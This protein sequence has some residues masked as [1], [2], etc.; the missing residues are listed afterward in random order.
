MAIVVQK[1][2]ELVEFLEKYDSISHMSFGSNNSKY[3][4]K[5]PSVLHDGHIK[6]INKAKKFGDV[7][8]AT[9][10]DSRA[11]WKY[12]FDKEYRNWYDNKEKSKF[13]SN[14]VVHEWA[15]FPYIDIVWI[16]D[17]N[18]AHNLF[19]P[20]ELDKKI[21]K[22]ENILE[23]ENISIKDTFEKN[24]IIFVMV[25]D[26]VRQWKKDYHTCCW[27]DG[28]YRFVQRYWAKKYMGYQVN[29]ID[30]VLDEYGIPFRETYL[31]HL[32]N[33][34]RDCFGHLH[35]FINKAGYEK[36][37]I[38]DFTNSIYKEAEKYKNN[39]SIFDI[40]IYSSH[41]TYPDTYITIDFQVAGKKRFS[42]RDL[43]N[44]V[45]INILLKRKQLT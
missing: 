11:S 26:G 1:A 21:K 20:P 12:Y 32:S 38:I 43:D 17:E 45:T 4:I 19:H 29:F 34:E 31:S 8:Y 36:N 39:L 42:I 2:H 7:L 9:L 15:L 22:A 41:I 30:P 33:I 24:A 3:S 14:E 6:A 18:E 23:R 27:Y 16:P 25:S 28:Y 35:R 10:H 13:I 44:R 5:L 40:S 37:T